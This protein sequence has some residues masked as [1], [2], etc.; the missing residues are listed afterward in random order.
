M[1]WASLA[2]QKR[3]ISVRST[4]LPG[5]PWDGVKQIP[6]HKGKSKKARKGKTKK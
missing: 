6:W 5:I 3:E 1:I 4:P 2:N